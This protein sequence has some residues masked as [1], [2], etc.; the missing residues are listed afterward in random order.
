M[1]LFKCL[2]SYVLVFIFGLLFAKSLLPGFAE[3]SYSNCQEIGHIHKYNFGKYHNSARESEAYDKLSENTASKNEISC[4]NEKS[5][6]NF[7][8][9]YFS[10]DE[11]NL[12]FYKIKFVLVL[13]LMNH[14]QF[15]YLEPN[16]KP[17]KVSS[18]IL[19][20]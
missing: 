19:L 13:S 1:G 18:S 14:F 20:A 8:F 7:G 15:P 12:K 9:R 6:F 17:P 11:F 5:I 3:T 16:K 4:H 10:T 2:V